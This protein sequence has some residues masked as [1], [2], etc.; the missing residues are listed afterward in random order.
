MPDEAG[1]EH[2]ELSASMMSALFEQANDA[3]LIETE[4]DGIIGVNRRACEL[5]GYTREELLAKR[6]G[7]LIAPEA[8][9]VETDIVRY[10]LA[11]FPNQPFETVDLHRDGHRIPVEVTE[12]RL[13]G[14]NSA[15]VLS[16]VR[17]ISERKRIEA[18]EHQRN[19]EL[20]ALRQ[21]GLQLTASLDLKTVLETILANALKLITADDAHIFLY[22]DE[23]LYFGAAL[24]ANPERDGPR[25]YHEP[26]SNGLTYAVAH[27]GQRIVVADT[28]RHELFRTWHWGGAIVGL[29]LRIGSE[30]RGVMNVAFV[31][32]HH[33]E[34]DELR[35]LELLADQATIAIENARLYEAVSRHAE[36][37]ERRVAERTAEL[38]QREAAL[39]AANESW[40]TAAQ[41][42]TEFDQFKTQF[43][44]NVSH[45][46][47]TPLTNIKLY[48]S[49]LQ[50]GKP[51]KHPHYLAT[52]QREVNLLQ[53][54]IEDLLHLS[55]LDLNEVQPAPDPL[56][57][58]QF[59]T[60]LAADRVALIA[61]R[62]LT[63]T[64]QTQPDLPT[65]LGDARLLTQVFTNLMTNAMNYTPS[66]GSITLSTETRSWRAEAEL[67]PAMDAARV[68]VT[69]S[70]SDTGP[71]ISAEDQAHLFER[72]Y[73]GTAAR[74][75]DVPG[76]GLGLAISDELV[77]RHGGRITVASEPGAGSTFTVWLP[78]GSREVPAC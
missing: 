78:A 57:I 75:S 51:G 68:W 11:H 50:N 62:G 13:N 46:L 30:V 14:P 34:A 29:P 43:L 74:Q 7:D 1:L 61:T 55:R 64:V 19:A 27:S 56:D 12:T 42:L 77:R 6:V 73:R 38:V 37:L 71:G 23:R 33:F 47:R 16:I 4:E 53:A 10:E 24:Q 54:L 72:F 49:L 40:R 63:L 66:G 31:T 52:L 2:N 44:S 5:M 3:I 39:Q 65:V 41:K 58:N 8:R 26:R 9:P 18:A 70:V 32:P 45:E 28:N 60:T 20:E 76:T 17:D 35:V 25:I 67:P 36:D 21:A 59:M 15:L 48:L 69:V 22:R